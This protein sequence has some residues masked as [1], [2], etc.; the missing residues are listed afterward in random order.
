MTTKNQSAKQVGSNGYD[1]E[2]KIN[3]LE[4]WGALEFKADRDKPIEIEAEQDSIRW[5]ARGYLEEYNEKNK[6]NYKFETFEFI[7][8]GESPLK[9]TVNAFLIP[10]AKEKEHDHD[11][12]GSPG[13]PPIG[14]SHLIPKEPPSPAGSGGS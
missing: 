10:P 11:H 7:E 1:T 13:G 14:G 4:A 3:W 9:F 8:A 5:Y 12:E 6:T 2:E